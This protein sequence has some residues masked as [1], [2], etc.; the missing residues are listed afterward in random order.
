MKTAAFK[1]A[2]VTGSAR[3][4]GRE[5]ALRL[6]GEGYYTFIHYLGS[7]REAEGVLRAIEKAGGRGALVRGDLG[8]AAE[9][10]ALADSVRAG[11][12][13]AGARGKSPHLDVL[14]NNVGVYKTGPLLDFS[15]DDFEATLQSNL[16]G[17]FRLI[18]ALQP[19]LPQGGSVI[20][21]GY[22]GVEALSGSTHNT[23]YLISKTGLLV[24]T[25]S[26][27]MSLAP[28]GVRVNMVSPGILS[29]SVELPEHPSD[30]VPAHRLGTVA[31]VTDAVEFLIGEGAGYITGINLDVAGGY[32]LALRSLEKDA[33][34][35]R[36][37]PSRKATLGKAT[38]GKAGRA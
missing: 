20:N 31:E 28:R 36:K 23:A 19:L 16:I 30:F 32:H 8:K 24:L 35:P 7:K 15:A 29:N 12:R 10:D 37:P 1:T 34:A 5:I 25:K 2:L 38:K 11:L 22:A 18:Q 9:V 13:A 17:T 33:R 27:A 3:R 26:L 21:I 14:V 6:A 4:L